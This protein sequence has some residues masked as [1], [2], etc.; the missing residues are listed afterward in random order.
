[1]QNKEVVPVKGTVRSS[2]PLF[3]GVDF[4]QVNERLQLFSKAAHLLR[5]RVLTGRRQQAKLHQTGQGQTLRV[6]SVPRYKDAW[7]LA[8]HNFHR[9]FSEY[10]SVGHKLVVHAEAHFVEE[11]WEAVGCS[12]VHT[13]PYQG[14]AALVSHFWLTQ[15]AQV[16]WWRGVGERAASAQY[17]RVALLA[18]EKVNQFVICKGLRFHVITQT[19]ET[20][21]KTF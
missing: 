15:V 14:V 3:A 13:V 9:T 4:F 11:L 8:D 5:R 12:H 16:P 17:E 7:K 10:V 18:F 2:V 19:S 21:E 20:V 6:L 1:M